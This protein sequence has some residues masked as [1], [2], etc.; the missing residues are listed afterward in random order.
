MSQVSHATATFPAPADYRRPAPRP[1]ALTSI[2][3]AKAATDHSGGTS[4]AENL[5]T[6]GAYEISPASDA[7]KVSLFAAGPEVE[8]AIEAQQRLEAQ[9][10]P[11]RVVAVPCFEL[12]LRQDDAARRAVIGDAPVRVAVAAGLAL[13]WGLF[14]GN[15][16]AFVGM[17]DFGAEAPSRKLD[18]HSG[19][20]AGAVARA[21]RKGLNQLR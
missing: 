19:I 12:F 3:S 18:E 4:V 9:G 14:L 6:R 11:T 10:T 1:A 2:G 7:A 17:P 15:A 5:F 16:G 13:G 8:I 21:A 20:D